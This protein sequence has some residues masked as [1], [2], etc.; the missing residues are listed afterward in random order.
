MA[1]FGLSYVLYIWFYIF[2]VIGMNYSLVR[3]I[4]VVFGFFWI[5]FFNVCKAADFLDPDAAFRHQAKVTAGQMVQL[6]WVIAPGYSLYKD[7]LHIV[8]GKTDLLPKLSL[9]TALKKF[10]TNFNKQVEVYHDRLTINIPKELIQGDAPFKLQYQGCSDEGLCYSPIDKN[11]Q[12]TGG[13]VVA[14]ADDSKTTSPQTNTVKIDKP[15]NLPTDEVSLAQSTLQSGS[16]IGIALS[17]LGFGLLLAFTPCVLP[18]VPILSSIIVGG[19][20][21]QKPQKGF[22]LAVAYSLGMVMVYTS[23]GVAAGLAGEGLAAALQKPSVLIFFASML[24]LLSLS[25]FDVYQLQ[26]PAFIQNRLNT[27]SM[28]MQGGRFVSVFIMGALSALI[29]GPCVAGPLAGALIYISQSRDVVLGGLALFSMAVGMS[30]PLLLTGASAGALLPKAGAWM[31]GVKYFFGLMLMATAIWMLQSVMPSAAWLAAWGAW[32]IA[33]AIFLKVFDGLSG[34]A[35]VGMRFGKVVS[36]FL[37]VAGVMELLGAGLG[38][39][40][41]LRPLEPLVASKRGGDFDSSRVARDGKPQLKFEKITSLAELQRQLQN[42][43]QLVMLD[44]YADW[45]TSCI[46]MEKFTFSDST[47]KDRLAD[48]K[49]LQIDVTKNSPADQQLMKQFKVFGPPAMLAFDLQG[50]EISSARVIGYL[51]P[52]KFVAHLD[53]RVLAKRAS[54]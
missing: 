14:L 31:T 7:K 26:L 52:E 41:V 30:V 46:E 33:C 20:D 42:S 18:M 16:L 6:D 38:A 13:R 35:S 47:V 8:F 51:A 28:N 17:F 1:I 39:K 32:L 34:H 50:N 19:S 29:V 21:S 48:V 44:F 25:M 2:E 37:L 11:F 9:P 15:A 43:K 24:F 12:L 53:G 23:L 54:I 22:L 40:D 36:V 3:R 10:D 49:L 27:S 45:C 4:I 5:G